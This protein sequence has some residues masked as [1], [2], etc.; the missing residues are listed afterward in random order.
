MNEPPEAEQLVA[1]VVVQVSVVVA[2][3]DEFWFTVKREADRSTVGG[4]GAAGTT[5]TVT[6]F[7]MSPPAPVHVSEYVV[8]ALGETI[9]FP[10]SAFAPLHPPL[11]VHD[12]ALVEAQV[13]VEV[14]T[15]VMVVGSAVNSNVGASGTAVTVTVTLSFAVPPAPVHEIA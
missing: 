5:L 9:W 10:E 7:A 12:V 15:V 13:S 6:F 14:P 11:A 2:V 1:F 4:F 8:V 3:E